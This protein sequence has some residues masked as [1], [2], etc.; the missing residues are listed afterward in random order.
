M[1][2]VAVDIL[3]EMGITAWVARAAAGAAA[4]P[5]LAAQ[6]QRVLSPKPTGDS[7]STTLAKAWDDLKFTVSRC[8]KCGLCHTRT[9]TV[10]GAGHRRADW[11]IIGEGPGQEEDR[12]GEPFVGPAGQLLGAMLRAAGKTR[13]SVYITNVVKCRPPSN[14]NPNRT[15]IAACASHLNHQIQLLQ[16]RLILA[17]GKVAANAVVGTDTSLAR[18]RGRVHRH[19]QFDIPIIA[20][21]HPAY[22]L[23]EPADKAKAW[24]DLKMAMLETA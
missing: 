21:Y 15:E 3:V 13:D 18:L 22:L 20:T 11:M 2:Q 14:R 9:Q 16:P 10:F 6:E 4:P 5:P 24:A 12:C 8:D 7:D 17:V 19:R 1:N 23:R